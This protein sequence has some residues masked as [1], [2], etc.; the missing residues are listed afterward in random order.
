[1]WKIL[2][3]QDVIHPK[4]SGWTKTDNGN[5]E[6]MHRIFLFWNDIEML[7][8]IYIY[9]WQIR[10]RSKPWKSSSIIWRLMDTLLEATAAWIL[11]THLLCTQMRTLLKKHK[12]I[13]KPPIIIIRQIKCTDTHL[14]LT[15]CHMPRLVF[16][17]RQRER[18]IE[19]KLNLSISHK[20]VIL[21]HLTTHPILTTLITCI[22]HHITTIKSKVSPIKNSLSLKYNR[23]S[24]SLN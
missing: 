11:I 17:W 16:R 1:M 22:L 14:I 12:K 20:Q 6:S 23:K 4:E 18:D 9:E 19:W 15:Q 7:I 2:I 13:R 3:S 21:I 10:W 8:Y 5:Q 24:N